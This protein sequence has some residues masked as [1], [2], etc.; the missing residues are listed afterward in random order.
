M[1]WT[2]QCP[3][4]LSAGLQQALLEALCLSSLLTRRGG[5]EI[6]HPQWKAKASSTSF[7]L[8][9][10]SLFSSQTHGVVILISTAIF[11]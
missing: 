11:T 8:W 2:G 10:K 3:F 1:T 7:G 9:S 6:G 4:P 5:A